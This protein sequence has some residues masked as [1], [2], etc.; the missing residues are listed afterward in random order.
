MRRCLLAFE[1]PDGGVAENVMRLALGLRAHGWDPFV[2]GPERSVI[3]PALA[4]ASIPVARLPF[5][6]GYRR[7]NRDVRALRSLIAIMRCERYDL[8]HAHA[9]KAGVLG[10]LAARATGTACIYSP[11][12]FPFVRPADRLRRRAFVAVER[13]LAGRTDAILCVA[14]AE[15]E[16]ALDNGI[17]PP[18]R[19][20]VVHNGSEPCPQ[21]V[22]PDRELAQFGEAGPVA[23]VM[24]VLRPQKAVDVFI[25]AVPAVLVKVPSARFAIVGQGEM[26]EQLRSRAAELG[27]FDRILFKSFEPPSARTLRAIDVFVLPSAWEAFPISVLEA[28]ACGIPQVATDVGGTAEA[29]VAGET[30]LL[31]PPGDPAAL[32]DRIA[33]LLGDEAMRRRMGAAA[34]A[35]H[36]ERFETSMMVESTA[37]L[38]ATAIGQGSGGNAQP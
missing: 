23:A 35:R 9:A 11:H 36:H 10:R 16:V 15:R 5:H 1:P 7:P 20:H 26:L 18:E 30:G 19:L 12:C 21:H 14:E 6:R 31:C 28:M 34:R 2:A 29:V 17:A 27:V 33:T 24:A 8:I 38:Y 13:S 32:A 37:A 3:Y 22:Q 25:E 4:D